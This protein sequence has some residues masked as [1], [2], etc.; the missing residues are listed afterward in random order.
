MFRIG[1]TN[2]FYCVL[3][4]RPPGPNN[5]FLTEFAEFLSSVVAEL[6]KVMIYGDFNIHVD[7]ASDKFAA[8]F[9]STTQSLKLTCIRA[10]TQ[11]WSYS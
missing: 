11:S 8:E 10:N 2:P 5:C 4:C 1:L 3:F 7:D 9:L 6:D